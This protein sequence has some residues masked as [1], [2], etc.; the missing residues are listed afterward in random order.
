MTPDAHQLVGVV[1]ALEGAR[2]PLEMS[3]AAEAL[4]AKELLVEG[5]VEVLDDG[6]APWLGE[7]NEAHLDA[8]R[9][10]GPY[11]QR[12]MTAPTLEGLP[13]VELGPTRH[14][15]AAPQGHQAFCH[16]PLLLALDDLDACSPAAE[17]DSVEGVEGEGTLEVAG[18]DE[19][20]LV[21]GVGLDHQ[22][23]AW[24]GGALGYVTVPV[25]GTTLGN[26]CARKDALDRSGGG[27]GDLELFHLPGDRH[28]S[29]LRPGVVLK[30]LADL[31]HQL[32]GLSCSVLW[33]CVLGARERSSAQVA[34]AGS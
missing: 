1:E 8:E 27:R 28:G 23:P 25:T 10:T 30:A 21:D 9:E 29:H 11:R 24:V 14:T 6:V 32:L 13:V 17:V 19:V 7:R 16:L 20:D 33:A 31:E 18:A 12:Q 26:A 34:S 2:P 3:Q 22:W 5:V 4:G 15:Q